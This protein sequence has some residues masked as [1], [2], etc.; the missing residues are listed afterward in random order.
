M[1]ISHQ[2]HDKYFKASLKERQIAVDFLKSHLQPDLYQ[3][4]DLSTLHLTDKSLHTPDFVEIHSDIVYRCQFDGQDGYI[5]ILFPPGA[6][7][8]APTHFAFRLPKFRVK[9]KNQSIKAGNKKI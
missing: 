4:L 3:R 7:S 5:P 6:F 2:P 9:P 1:S 8:T